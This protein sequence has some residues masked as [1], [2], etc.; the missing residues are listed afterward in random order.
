MGSRFEP[1]RERR[2]AASGTMPT[3]RNASIPVG[4]AGEVRR[5]RRCL[6]RNLSGAVSRPNAL[7][8][9][10]RAPAIFHPAAAQ[11]CLLPGAVPSATQ[12]AA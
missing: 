2:V 3:K 1:P 9:S 11:P 12:W 8:F 7:P 10:T 4:D 5:E 6:L